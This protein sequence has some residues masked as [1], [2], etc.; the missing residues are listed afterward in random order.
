ETRVEILFENHR[1]NAVLKALFSSHPYEEVAYDIYSLENKQS[2][3]GSGRIGTLA[4]PMEAMAFLEQLKN[5]FGGGVRYTALTG[6]KVQR[7]ALC[8]G[9]GSFLLED[10]VAA[11]ADVLVTADFKYHQ[12]L[13]ADN[14]IIIADIGH[15]ESEQFTITLLT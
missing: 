5:S 4:Q 6:K 1:Q 10:A 13:E 8:G 7:I 15:F 9:S 11:G 2:N 12:F 3:V 14:R